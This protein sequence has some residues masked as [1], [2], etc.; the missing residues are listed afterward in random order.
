[1]ADFGD[2]IPP[3]ARKVIDEELSKLSN[4]EPSSAEFSV[5]R[6]YLDWLTSIPWGR[7]LDENANIDVAQRVLD[8]DHWGLEDVK[9][10]ILEFIA[11][12][13]L[14][15]ATAGKIVCLVGPPGVGK[16][17]IG[18]SI[19]RALGRDYYRFSVGGLRDVAEIKGHR[20]TYVGAMPGKMVQ[21]LKSCGSANPLVLIDEIDKIGHGTHGVG[22]LCSCGVT[23]RA[24]LGGYQG[25]PASA[26][27]E[28]LDP[29]QNDAFMDH[30]LDVAVDLSKVRSAG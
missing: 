27:L 26:L 13:Q 16:T 9:E 23:L 19:A 25:D 3:D 1:M 24:L 14:R 6:N 8:E 29:E 7:Y 30:Y 5:T 4:L 22:M 28:L 15:G 2:R 17:S 12:G 21:C 20:R 10:R 18:K 11:V